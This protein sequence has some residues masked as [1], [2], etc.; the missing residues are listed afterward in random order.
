MMR[1]FVERGLIFDKD[2]G[3]LK[4]KPEGHPFWT[5]GLFQ[6]NLRCFFA[7]Y[8]ERNSR[9]RVDFRKKKGFFEK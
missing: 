3:F 9:A 6:N 8:P 5:A 4:K 1:G 7:K 2:K